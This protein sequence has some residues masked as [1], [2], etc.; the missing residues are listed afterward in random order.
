MMTTFDMA[1]KNY[2]RG[3]WT[4]EM[5]GRLVDKGKLTVSEYE[6]VTGKPYSVVTPGAAGNE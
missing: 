5:V 2:S 1:V 6:T 3:L 4:D